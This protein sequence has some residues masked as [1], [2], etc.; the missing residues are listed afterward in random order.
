MCWI[1]DSNNDPAFQPIV[2]DHGRVVSTWVAKVEAV[3]LSQREIIERRSLVQLKK[4]GISACLYAT[5]LSSTVGCGVYFTRY[6]LRGTLPLTWRPHEAISQIP[7]D[8]LAL[9]FLLKPAVK[10]LKPEAI[11]AAYAKRWWVVV[12][13][14][15]G[16]GQYLVGAKET[17]TS[18]ADVVWARVPDSDT[19]VPGPLLIWT[20]AEGEPLTAA[21]REAR[22]AQARAAEPMTV[23]PKYLQLKLPRH[24]RYRLISVIASLWLSICVCLV[25]GLTLPLITGRVIFHRIGLAPLHDFYSYSVGLALCAAFCAAGSRLRRFMR[26]RRA[27][28]LRWRPLLVRAKAVAKRALCRAWIIIAVRTCL[29]LTLLEPAFTAFFSK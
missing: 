2:C 4:I 23:K 3:S 21:G 25:A 12:S 6:C 18:T 29:L 15:F 10:A 9:L 1:R 14:Y 27:A 5:V 26:R 28:R 24:F 20:D 19:I 7:F 8:L 17:S 22:D 13:T 16:L 11:F